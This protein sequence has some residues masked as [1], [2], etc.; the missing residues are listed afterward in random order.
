[1]DSNIH[2][3]NFVTIDNFDEIIKSGASYVVVHKDM[4]KEFLF[5]RKNFPDFKFWVDV[6]EKNKAQYEL[7]TLPAR[8]EAARTI[9][10][11]RQH[12]GKPF[13]ED[14]LI[15]V[16]KMK[17]KSYPKRIIS[18]SLWQKYRAHRQR[19]GRREIEAC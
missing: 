16:F 1:M 10:F 15:I 2:F 12:C 4:V 13:Y 8:E 7:Y 19:R 9:S 11:L 18:C 5:I 3:R 6:V 14:A 17:T